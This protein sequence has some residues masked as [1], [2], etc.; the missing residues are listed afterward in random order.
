MSAPPVRVCALPAC[1]TALTANQSRYCSREH[2]STR[3]RAVVPDTKPCELDGCT[4]VIVRNHRTT[5]DVAWA[6]RKYCCPAHGH[7]GKVGKPQVQVHGPRGPRP[8]R[9]RPAA[10]PCPTPAPAPVVAEPGVWRPSAPGWHPDGPRCA[11]RGTR[12]TFSA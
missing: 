2:V 12:A 4:V 3:P 8:R 7:A 9:V 1:T 11:G 6:A 10:L 5:G